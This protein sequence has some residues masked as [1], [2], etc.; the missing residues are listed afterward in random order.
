M[1]G[2]NQKNSSFVKTGD[3]Q[4]AMMNIVALYTLHMEL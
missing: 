3:V 4:G 2:T 1:S